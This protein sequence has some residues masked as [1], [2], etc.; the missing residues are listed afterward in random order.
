MNA[1]E[2][3]VWLIDYTMYY[4]GQVNENGDIGALIE[5]LRKIGHTELIIRDIKHG[6]KDMI[7]QVTPASDRAF[8]TLKYSE[9]L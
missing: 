2:F 7:R 3:E 9:Y 5:C 6:V 1:E 4:S 8:L